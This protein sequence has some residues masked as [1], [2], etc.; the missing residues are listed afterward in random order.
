[1]YVIRVFSACSY[2]KYDKDVGGQPSTVYINE[3]K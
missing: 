3:L 1:M 2:K